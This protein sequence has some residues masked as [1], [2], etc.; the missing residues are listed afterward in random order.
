MGEDNVDTSKQINNI[1]MKL[2][3]VDKALNPEIAGSEK[4]DFVSAEK[5]LKTLVTKKDNILKK[6][7]KEIFADE[8]LSLKRNYNRTSLEEVYEDFNSENKLGKTEELALR[9]KIQQQTANVHFPNM[10]NFAYQELLGRINKVRQES[11]IKK[12]T[13]SFT[14]ESEKWVKAGYDLHDLSEST[15]EINCY[16]CDQKISDERIEELSELFNTNYESTQNEIHRI[17]V[18]IEQ[19][20]KDV[21]EIPLLEKDRA[22][23]EFHEDIIQLNEMIRH[24]QKKST[25]LLQN[26]LNYIDEK[27]RNIFKK[28]SV[29]LPKNPPSSLIINNM[30]DDLN[31]RMTSYTNDIEN[32]KSEYRK[33]L[34]LHL[35]TTVLLR[36]EIRDCLTELN[37]QEKEVEDKRKIIV[38]L[39][40]N[41]ASLSLEKKELIAETKNETVLVERVNRI[42]KEMGNKSFELCYVEPK[43]DEMKGQYQIKGYEGHRRSIH[44]LSKGEKNLIAFLW[45]VNNISE[46]SD[47]NKKN[48]VVFDDLMDSNDDHSQ[49]LMIAVLNDLMTKMC[50]NSENQFFILTHNIHF[51]MQLKPSKPQYKDSYRNGTLIKQSSSAFFHLNK[52]DSRTVVKKIENQNEDISTVYDNL[53]GELYFA[54]YNQKKAFMWNTMRRIFESYCRFVYSKESPRD[55]S[56]FIKKNNPNEGNE[57]LYIALLKSLHVNSHVAYET[58]TDLSNVDVEGLKEMFEQTFVYLNVKDHFDTYWNRGKKQAI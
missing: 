27:D 13:L 32:H 24:F 10:K 44:E 48:I 18:D 55:L 33:Q 6:Y 14:V 16:F 51:Y 2:I 43:E 31:S 39:E 57:L 50:E 15:H 17:K 38:S 35:E 25:T 52:T 29:Y 12:S 19:M 47:K 8:D 3:D 23:V 58:D 1:N 53:W 37:H 11:V 22:Y 36:K 40:K 41:A 42:L 54:Y 56:D 46:N 5:I 4:S 28:L 21:D 49:Y 30:I 20:K 26:F 7:A 45:F 34:Q 9:K